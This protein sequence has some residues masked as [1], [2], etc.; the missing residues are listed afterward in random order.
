MLLKSLNLLQ[1][2]NKFHFNT[3]INKLYKTFTFQKFFASLDVLRKLNSLFETSQ[4]FRCAE[5]P[6]IFVLLN[7]MFCNQHMNFL[8]D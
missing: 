4:E 2:Q 6:V 7:V 8:I 3:R 5:F 1:T